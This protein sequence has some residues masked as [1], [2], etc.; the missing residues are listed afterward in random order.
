MTKRELF[1]YIETEQWD[2]LAL[3]IFMKKT[4]DKV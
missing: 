2:F 4:L 1:H 3:W